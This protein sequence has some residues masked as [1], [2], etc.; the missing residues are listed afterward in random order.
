MLCFVLL[1]E[2]SIP[3]SILYKK[4]GFYGV[5]LVLSISLSILIYSMV[6]IPFSKESFT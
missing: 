6:G 4:I 3:Q 5:T 2:I 1:Y